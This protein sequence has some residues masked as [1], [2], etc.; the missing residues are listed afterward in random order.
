ME[1]EQFFASIIID[2][3]LY[4]EFLSAIREKIPYEITKLA[5]IVKNGEI[6][7]IVKSLVET[8][9]PEIPVLSRSELLPIF[10]N[11]ILGE[12]NVLENF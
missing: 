3:D 6:R 4:S 1:K 9:F 5:I 2:P 12:M 8:E 7:H 11:N 10:E